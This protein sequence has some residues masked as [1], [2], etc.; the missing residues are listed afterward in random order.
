MQSCPC[1]GTM[2]VF[3]CFV[4]ILYICLYM[5]V[6]LY[7]NV[8]ECICQYVYICLDTCIQV[9]CLYMYVVL[10]SACMCV[11]HVFS[12]IRMITCIV[13]MYVLFILHVYACIFQGRV[14][15]YIH[16]HTNT[17]NTCKYANTYQ[18]HVKPKFMY[19]CVYFD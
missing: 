10:V 2:Y 17:S 19:L 3:V 18:I 12:C 7:L 8:F 13:C 11:L 6:S 15:K 1:P 5:Y 14:S 16:I 4:C 9:Y